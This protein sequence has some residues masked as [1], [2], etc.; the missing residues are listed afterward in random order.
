MKRCDRVFVLS[1]KQPGT[2][3]F[4]QVNDAGKEGRRRG[5]EEKGREVGR[6]KGDVKRNANLC[7]SSKYQPR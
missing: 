5:M 2:S 4:L 1:E 7:C 6:E 3:T